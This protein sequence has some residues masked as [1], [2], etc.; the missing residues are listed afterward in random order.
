MRGT[1]LL[2]TLGAM[3]VTVLSVG[4]LVALPSVF[5]QCNVQRLAPFFVSLRETLA[6]LAPANHENP[7]VVLLTPGP[8]NETY[9]EHDYLARYLGFTLIE[10]GDLTV[11]D[12]RVFLKTLEV[13]PAEYRRRFQALSAR[14]A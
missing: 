10:G 3:A 9:F 4:L 12:N 13:G 5:R 14:A 7:R 6:S 1:A 11:R 2:L 8:Y